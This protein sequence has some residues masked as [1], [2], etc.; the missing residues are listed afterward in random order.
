MKRM[1]LIIAI[2]V[3]AATASAGDGFF[4]FALN[5]EDC[6][7]VV[8]TSPKWRRAQ[9][10]KKAADEFRKPTAAELNVSSGYDVLV[11]TT[12]ELQCRGVRPNA[13]V[14]SDKANNVRIRYT[15][16]PSSEVKANAFGVTGTFHQATVRLQR[17]AIAD[18][19]AEDGILHVLASDGRKSAPFDAALVAD[20]LDYETAVQRQARQDAH[21]P[22]VADEVRAS[23]RE[24]CSLPKDRGGSK[25]FGLSS[26]EGKI[27][28]AEAAS[29]EQIWLAVSE[30]RPCLE[31]MAA[32]SMQGLSTLAARFLASLGPASAP[33]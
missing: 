32:D 6:V 14:V 24:I 8:I 23:L 18:A 11:W 1:M 29:H 3:G 27:G 5:D 7:N 22:R 17:A 30:F 25:Y 21:A 13:I 28:K 9:A 12:E 16:A 10:D 15:L 26:I 2:L 4:S 33:K 31:T 20:S 19:F